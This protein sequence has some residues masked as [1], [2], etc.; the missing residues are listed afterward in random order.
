MKYFITIIT[1]LITSSLIAQSLGSWNVIDLKK[2]TKS[3]YS[4]QLEAQ[5][6]S[7]KFYQD[8]HYNELNFTANYK[9]DNNLVLSMLLG[10]HNTY[11]E[12]GN[13][14]SPIVKD[15]YRLSVQASTFQKFGIF[16]LD[17]RYRIE[18]RYFINDHSLSYRMRYRFG[19]KNKITKF[20]NL[21]FSNEFF[22]A[23]GDKNS[24]FEKNRFLIGITN[25]LSK[26]YE[27]QFN[28]LNQIDNRKNDESGSNFFQFVN[29]LSF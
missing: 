28:Y 12:G 7:L 20:N 14:T 19:L 24:T 6:R 2:S 17:N 18:Q 1:T 22:L 4:Y 8:F 16:Y 13:F 5:L 21:Q 9:Y 26:R 23:L 3:K 10:K 15:E 27:V 29:I 25:T 11:T